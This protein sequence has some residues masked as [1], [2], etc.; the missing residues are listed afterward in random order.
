MAYHEVTRI[1]AA[2]HG[3]EGRW[4]G[5][6]TS[7][8]LPKHDPEIEALTREQRAELAAVWLGRAASER[9]VADAFVVVRQALLDAGSPGPLVSLA[10]RA[11]DDEYRHAE[12]ARVV[13]ERFAGEPLEPPARLPLAV[14]R[15]PGASPELLRTLHILGHCALNETFASAF[16]EATLTLTSAPLARAAVRELL[17]DEVDHARIGWGHLASLNAGT[18]ETLIPWLVPLVSGN[19]SMWRSA[20]R[21]YPKDPALHRH[22]A[23]PAE[24]IE[25]TLLNAIEELVIPGFEYFGLPTEDLRAFH[26]RGALTPGYVIA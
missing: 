23:P 18:R 4:S 13:A 2:R 1:E 14:P 11:V 8:P 3:A 12:L 20:P 16:L 6:L 19:L 25:R 17:A 21:P 24:L 5:K 9:R 10:T 7:R 15:H 22:G 26:A